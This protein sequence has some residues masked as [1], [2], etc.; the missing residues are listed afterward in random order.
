MNIVEF[1]L[2][3]MRKTLHKLVDCVAFA[4]HTNI[5]Y[6]SKLRLLLRNIILKVAATA[7]E[8]VATDLCLSGPKILN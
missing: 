7:T 1:Y 5:T 6:P 3:F 8:V 4:D 2:D